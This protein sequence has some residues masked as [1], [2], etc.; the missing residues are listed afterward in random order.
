M[1]N[2]AEQKLINDNV[3]TEKNACNTHNKIGK[4]VRR[5][6][7]EIGGIMPEKYKK[8]NKSLKELEKEN[9]NQIIKE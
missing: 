3:D 6:I 7:K 1:S 9:K 4:I 8:T 2:F 5:E